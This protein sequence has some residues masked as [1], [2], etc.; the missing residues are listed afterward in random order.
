MLRKIKEP[1]Q[2][3]LTV[4]GSKFENLSNLKFMCEILNYNAMFAKL[5]GNIFPVKTM[6]R[7]W[8][9]SMI[10]TT[11]RISENNLKKW[12]R[13]NVISAFKT[14]IC[15]SVTKRGRFFY[16]GRFYTRGRIMRLWPFWILHKHR[17]QFFLG[18]TIALRELENN[19][20]EKGLL[21]IAFFGTCDV[22][23][24]GRH[25]NRN[26]EFYCNSD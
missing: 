23:Q 20:Y 11:R 1:T 12:H 22:L 19:A 18:L 2:C 17:F 8:F 16:N 9:C 24:C 6:N 4:L 10:P 3:S 13:K 26:R 5:G 15:F 7:L 21:D 25:L 14:L